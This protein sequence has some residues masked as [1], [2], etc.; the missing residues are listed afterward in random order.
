MAGGYFQQLEKLLKV[1]ECLAKHRGARIEDLQDAL[2]CDERTV[3]RWINVLEDMGFP[4]EEVGE[5]NNKKRYRLIDTYVK[6]MPNISIPDFRL[7]LSDILLLRLILSQDRITLGTPLKQ[8]RDDIVKRLCA[9]LTEK[10]KNLVTAIENL[11]VPNRK[12]QKDY[13]EKKEI[14]DVLTEAILQK[15]RCSVGYYSFSKKKFSR[16]PIHP[17]HFFES[18]GGLYVMVQLVKMDEPVSDVV[19]TLRVLAVERIHDIAITK[20]TFE[21][22]KGLNPVDLLSK[23]FDVVWNQ[24]VRIKVWF[25][26]NAAP[27]IKERAWPGKVLQCEEQGDGSLIFELE[28][29]GYGDVKRW[30]LSFGSDA[31]VLEPDSLRKDILQTC[32]EMQQRYTPRL[33]SGL[34]AVQGPS[35]MEV[36]QW[37][38]AAS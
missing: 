28:T 33:A 18:Q 32:H 13:S 25:S 21:Y 22:P 7:T 36:C 2:G 26:D 1:V 4:I 11:V 16:F 35:E 29:S 14:I 38:G 5:D 24:P 34:Q 23:A 37:A 30:I 3:Y 9:T 17:L 19:D 15:R 8:R 12:P 20:E 27:Y 31:E 6:K 10:E